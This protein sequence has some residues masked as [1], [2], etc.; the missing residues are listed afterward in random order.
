MKCSIRV[1]CSAALWAKVQA[2]IE[3]TR[4]SVTC[5]YHQGSVMI[6]GPITEAMLVLWAI[7]LASR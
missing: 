1:V 2:A 3:L 5:T 7:E 6:E 4:V